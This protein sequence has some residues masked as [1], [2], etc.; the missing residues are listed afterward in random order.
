MSGHTFA[1][2][3][4]PSPR[5][6]DLRLACCNG[7][8]WNS[9]GTSPSQDTVAL[10][11]HLLSFFVL[12]PSFFFFFCYPIPSVS[13]HPFFSFF[14]RLPSLVLL[15]PSSLFHLP[16]LVFLLSCFFFFLLPVVFRLLFFALRL[17]SPFVCLL[18]FFFRFFLSAFF[19]SFFLSFFRSFVLSS[20]A[21]GVGSQKGDKKRPLGLAS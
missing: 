21:T 20:L 9:R 4:N 18:A 3:G 11:L 7:P 12:H 6:A 5:R 19:L 17:C 1:G 8:P 2:K 15:L 16:S 10:D 14:F 13:S